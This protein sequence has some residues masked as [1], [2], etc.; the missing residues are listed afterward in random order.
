MKKMILASVLAFGLLLTIGLDAKAQPAKEGTYSFKYIYSGPF[1]TLQMREERL[2][3]TYE[4]MGVHVSDTGEGLLHNASFR[5]IGM[6]HVVK[7]MFKNSGSIVFTCPDGDQVFVTF[8]GTG[9]FGV[10]GGYSGTFVGGTGK[11]VGIEG[12]I[13]KWTDYAVR[14][15]AEG[16]IQGLG[17][18]EVNWKLP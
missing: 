2:H 18:G 6:L 7:G 4:I 3:M 13:T 12:F 14:P 16:T 5:C 8:E 15:A 1:K 11:L 10:G 9:K 17:R